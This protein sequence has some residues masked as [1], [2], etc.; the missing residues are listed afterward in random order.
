MRKPKMAMD[1]DINRRRVT[2]PFG[3]T[4]VLHKTKAEEV[5]NAGMRVYKKHK[6][7]SK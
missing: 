2:T 7:R 1:W 6:K 4:L 3:E 5:F